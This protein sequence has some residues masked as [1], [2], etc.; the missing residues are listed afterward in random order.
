M[1]AKACFIRKYAALEFA[2]REKR[3]GA[4]LNTVGGKSSGRN[5]VERIAHTF[6]QFTDQV[7][8]RICGILPPTDSTGTATNE[9]GRVRHD[10]DQP[11][12]RGQPRFES[13]QFQTCSDGND[14][15]PVTQCGLV[16]TDHLL[17]QVRFHG[18][19][20]KVHCFQDGWVCAHRAFMIQQFRKC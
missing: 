20:H 14:Q 15:L 19:Y 6:Q 13:R 9:T 8:I 18:K 11:R 16:L 7:F 17:H 10:S 12:T 1:Q 3:K 2:R 4:G 5:R